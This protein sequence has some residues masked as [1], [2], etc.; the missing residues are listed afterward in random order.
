MGYSVKLGS[1]PLLFGIA[2]IVG[3]A[4]FTNHAVYF[5]IAGM[6]F[7][8]LGEGLA[9]AVLYR[10]ALM[11]SMVAKGTVSASMTMLS[12][13]VYALGVECLKIVWLFHGMVGLA[14]AMLALVIVFRFLSSRI[15][16]SFMAERAAGAKES[17]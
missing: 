13:L 3:G 16:D 11:S 15:V 17:S 10:F 6:C 4:L 5:L 1:W 14:L 8:G 2:L 9:T 12:M 7:I